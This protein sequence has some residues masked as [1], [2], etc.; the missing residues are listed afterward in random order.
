[1]EEINL[2]LMA[3]QPAY[4]P[5][6]DKIT[7]LSTHREIESSN[8]LPVLNYT[9]S[10]Q[11]QMEMIRTNFTTEESYM[12]SQNQLNSYDNQRMESDNPNISI[13]NAEKDSDYH[14]MQPRNSFKPYGSPIKG[15]NQDIVVK[16]TMERE[17]MSESTS[18]QNVAED[19]TEEMFRKF[20]EFR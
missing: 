3:S 8:S 5:E 7:E 12:Y 11:G 19:S 20:N 13:I 16:E 18:R 2:N 4:Y 10:S 15:V 17:E 6:Q 1:M 9:R 14:D